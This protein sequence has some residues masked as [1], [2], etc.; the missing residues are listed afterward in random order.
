MVAM[1][2]MRFGYN[3]MTLDKLMTI[4]DLMVRF[5]TSNPYV[6][7]S[8]GTLTLHVTDEKLC[9]CLTKY[10]SLDENVPSNR[11]LQEQQAGRYTGRMNRW[12]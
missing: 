9:L 11:L 7:L 8:I 1:L 2:S 10:R 6:D 12:S 4:D 3:F 5:E